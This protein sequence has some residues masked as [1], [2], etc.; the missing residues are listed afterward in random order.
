MGKRCVDELL[1]SPTFQVT[2]TSKRCDSKLTPQ[3]DKNI[4]DSQDAERNQEISRIAESAPEWF[5]AAFNFLV[6]E[7]TAL[8]TDNLS[9]RDVKREMNKEIDTLQQDISILSH[10]NR[11]QAV[12]IDKLTAKVDQLEEYSRRPNLIIDGILET[13]NE[14][15]KTKVFSFFHDVLEVMDV[16]EPQVQ[17]IHRLG[18]PPHLQPGAVKRPRSIIVRFQST[19]DRDKIWKASWT[20]RKPGIYVTE[21]YPKRI[22]ENRSI[23]LPCFKAAKRDQAV[24]HV[25]LKR[26]LLI[27]DGTTYSVDSV[28]KLPPRL[29]WPT[30]GEKYDANSNRTFFFGKRT[31]LSNFY[32]CMFKD[33]G[34]TYNCSEQ[35]FLQQKALYFKDARIAESIMKCTEPEQMKTLSHKI[36]NVDETQWRKQA[37][38]AMKKSCQLKFN[39]NSHLQ[40]MLINCKGEIVE[41]NRHDKFFSC[42]LGL[43]DRNSLDKSKWEGSNILGQIL[44]EM[45]EHYKQ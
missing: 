13:P 41:A 18:K 36:A 14:N 16:R 24:S 27:I 45:R 26:D 6:K 38:E 21:D 28:D 5:S 42:G 43:S 9:L 22:K 8:R 29:Q 2:H 32:P 40:K 25:S 17:N 20:H 30:K 12:A 1:T 10:L 37:G 7:M 15:I 44:M 3:K 35:H 39:Q 19:E 23:L 33:K 4:M 34:V 11:E 31:F